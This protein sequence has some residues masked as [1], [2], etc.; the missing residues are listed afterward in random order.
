MTAINLKID[1][2]QKVL[3]AIK[4]NPPTARVGILGNG[5]ARQGGGTNNAT[6]GAAHEFGTSSLPIRSFL[7]VPI[8]EHLQP[9]LEK[10]GAF[11]EDA[12]NAVVK[13]KSLKPWVDKM[14]V[15][16]EGIVAQAFDSGGFGKWPALNAKTMERKKV[17]QI[18]VETQ[19]LRNSITSEV[20]ENA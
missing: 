17:K 12:L 2:L 4:G 19:Q 15:V 13:Q 11:T 18:L 5:S 6:I 14:A 20:K 1:G 7:R 16:A 8:S 10:S 9:E 3:K